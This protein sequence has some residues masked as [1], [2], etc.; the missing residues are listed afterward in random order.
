MAVVVEKEPLIE[1][2]TGDDDDWY[3][4]WRVSAQVRALQERPA[5]LCGSSQVLYY[6]A[7][8]DAAWEY[9]YT[10]PGAPWV[11]GNTLVYRKSLWRQH[12]FPD[13]Q[14][15][16]D[17]RFV[18]SIAKRPLVDLANPKLCIGAVHPGNTSRKEIHGAFWHT[19]P[20]AR[21]HALWGD[22]RYFYSHAS[23][24]TR[25]AATSATTA[26]PLVSC[27]MPTYN[28][29]PFVPLALRYFLAQDYPNK[30]LVIIDD[31]SDP[32]SDLV[33]GVPGVRYIRL[34][35]RSSIGAKRNLACQHACG[36]LIAHWDD[37][38]WYAPDRLRYQAAPILAGEAELTGLENAFVLE[39]TTGVFWRTQ[40]DLHQRMFVGDVH[41]GT[42]V[43]RKAI[44]QEGR[45]YPEVNL[46]EDA[47]LLRRAV[48]RGKRLR[49]LANPGVFLYIRHGQN[50]WREFAP[51][52]FLNP[53]GW[54]RTTPPLCSPHP[55]WTR[56]R[57]SACH[58]AAVNRSKW[59]S[60]SPKVCAMVV[61]RRKVWLTLSSSVIPMPP[62]SW[63][64]S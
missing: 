49:R 27:I 19:T 13:I 52:I 24:H 59:W 31:G 37:D 10:A 4:S 55:A 64:D 3:P 26:L 14:V 63:T 44:W 33:E 60:A 61:N 39:L 16:E 20:S 45:R 29:R 15:G 50:A 51:G 38:D 53:S 43:Y 62:C 12:Q 28:R 36:E 42:L 23:G 30:E 48:A 40:P 17:S 21:V 34:S 58:K 46:A 5:D 22:D 2:H 57:M 41:G 11:A 56:I 7:A 35:S 18:W 1:P 54:E 9:R 8:A 32:L 47:W 6:D 25:L